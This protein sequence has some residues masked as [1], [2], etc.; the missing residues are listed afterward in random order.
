M[1]LSSRET[2]I[3]LGKLCL[4]F[5][6]I[7]VIP[8]KIGTGASNNSLRLSGIT[9]IVRF[10]HFKGLISDLIASTHDVTSPRLADTKII[11]FS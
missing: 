9:G 6:S 3:I 7:W 5:E 1:S 11:V 2:H 8:A 10:I 4:S